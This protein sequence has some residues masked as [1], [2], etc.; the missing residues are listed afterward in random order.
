MTFKDA[1][2]KHLDLVECL[3][4]GQNPELFEPESCIKQYGA[5]FLENHTVEAAANLVWWILFG[6]LVEKHIPYVD[7]ARQFLKNEI[8]GIEYI[9]RSH[10]V[11]CDMEEIDEKSSEPI[12]H[13]SEMEEEFMKCLKALHLSERYHDLADY[14]LAL[15]YYHGI[16]GNHYSVGQN[17]A[18]AGEMLYSFALLGNKYALDFLS[19]AYE[20]DE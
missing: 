12:E 3:K 9:R 14:Y 13:D 20:K 1:Y 6:R 4:P 2:L 11:D 5:S 15:G 18:I 7:D 17:I 19:F 8:S 16:I 10:L